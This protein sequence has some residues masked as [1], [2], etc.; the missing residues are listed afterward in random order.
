[1]AWHRRAALTHGITH[2]PIGPIL[3]GILGSGEINGASEPF[4]LP[5]LNL[6]VCSR[7]DLA[8]WAGQGDP[9]C[10]AV[11]VRIFRGF[12]Q[13]LFMYRVECGG[14]KWSFVAEPCGNSGPNRASFICFVFN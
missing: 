9:F 4:V 7:Q 10:Y 14:E 6:A 3:I 1:M 5:S 8:A 2:S 13:D 12:P 11:G